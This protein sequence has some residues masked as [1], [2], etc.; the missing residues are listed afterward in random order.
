MSAQLKEGGNAFRVVFL[1]DAAYTHG[2][3][4]FLS[5][6]LS[7]RLIPGKIVEIVGTRTL[8]FHFFPHYKREFLFSERWIMANCKEEISL[9]EQRLPRFIEELRLTFLSIVRAR[10]FLSLKPEK[11]EGKEILLPEIRHLSTF[12]EMQQIVQRLSAEKTMG[13]IRHAIAPFYQR[14]P[15]I[16]DRDIFEEMKASLAFYDEAFIGKRP[17]KDVA[18]LICYHFYF[19]KQLAVLREEKPFKRHLLL[20]IFR[21]K[22]RVGILVLL[23]LFRENELLKK[24]HLLQALSQ[25]VKE[26][27]EIEGSFLMDTSTP[28]RLFFYIEIENI[29][30][31]MEELQVLKAKLPLELKKSIQRTANPLFMLRN[32][33]GSDASFDCT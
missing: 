18:R 12:E 11:W 15:K 33:R 4:R 30:F 22:G 26:L 5:D 29:N 3:G 2:T 20:K 1:S 25:C 28:S 16:F 27:K 6:A 24:Q 9:I 23:N 7:R 10:R 13:E 8:S 32:E 31:S 14:R 19:Q 21:K 17:A